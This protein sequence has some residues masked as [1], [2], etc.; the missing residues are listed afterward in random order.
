MENKKSNFKNLISP[1]EIIEEISLREESSRV[2][3][4]KNGIIHWVIL[5]QEKNP[6]PQEEER[7]TRETLDAIFKL[8]K[9]SPKKTRILMDFRKVNTAGTAKTRRMLGDALKSG[10]FGKVAALGMSV[11]VQIAAK[12]VMAYA[13]VKFVKF[14]NNK[15]KA[16]QW[17]KK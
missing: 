11:F 1:K 2:Y 4:D 10:I 12:F 15:K 13:K 14:F 9:K 17:L 8:A 3:L 16:L 5:F 6:D 7:H